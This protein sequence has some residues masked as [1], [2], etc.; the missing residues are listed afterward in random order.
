MCSD[1]EKQEKQLDKH[2]GLRLC[3]IAVVWFALGGTLLNSENQSTF[4]SALIL[5]LLPLTLDYN[6]HLPK[7]KKNKSRQALGLWSSVGLAA[8]FVGMSFSGFNFEA[9][10]LI[11][12]V[13]FLIWILCL[14]YVYLAIIDWIAYSSL[15]ETAY[16]QRIQTLQRERTRHES[17]PERVEYYKDGKNQSTGTSIE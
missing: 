8:V 6:S 13:Q 2:F 7:E 15:E 10:I 17:M 4:F 14:F 12:W 5:Y 1:L 16:R 9:V 11:D 3:C